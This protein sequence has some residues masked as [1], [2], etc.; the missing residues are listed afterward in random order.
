MGSGNGESDVRGGPGFRTLVSGP[1][2]TDCCAVTEVA[3]KITKLKQL[4]IQHALFINETTKKLSYTML[5]HTI[6]IMY[7]RLPLLLS[8]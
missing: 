1:S 5:D 6:N 8:F 3:E 2:K 4:T 7:W